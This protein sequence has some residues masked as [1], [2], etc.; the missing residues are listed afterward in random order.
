MSQN[1]N[2]FT[3]GD[4]DTLKKLHDAVCGNRFDPE[5]EPGLLKMQ[6][7]LT[8]EI[9]GH[10]G[11]QQIGLKRAHEETEK[12]VSVLWEGRAKLLFLGS[13]VGCVGGVIGWLLIFIFKG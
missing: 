5:N 8:R 2:Q 7:A 3:E 1:Q 10:E 11:T 9:Y 12:R 4:R 6:M 13:I